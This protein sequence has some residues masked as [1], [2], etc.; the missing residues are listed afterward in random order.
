MGSRLPWYP[1]KSTTYSTPMDGEG[2]QSQ[3][4]LALKEQYL[5]H[6]IHSPVQ[7]ETENIGIIQTMIRKIYEKSYKK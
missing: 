4:I 7:N 3:E 5:L 1:L 2:C 6:D